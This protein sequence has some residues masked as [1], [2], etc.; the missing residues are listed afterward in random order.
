MSYSKEVISKQVDKIKETFKSWLGE[1]KEDY[2]DNNAVGLGCF[3]Y[4]PYD[5]AWAVTKQC[6]LKCAHCSISAGSAG[7]D[8]LSTEEGL[9][10]I[11][12]VANLGPVKFVFTGGE[13]L[14]R[15]DIF[16]LIEYA[17]SLNMQVEVATNGTLIDDNVAKRLKNAGVYEVAISMDGIGKI[18]D[19]IR[20]IKGTFDKAVRAIKAC[21]KAG[22]KVHF[23]TT[24]FK[25]NISE[26]SR[27]VDFAEQLQVDRI[28]IGTLVPVGRGQKI[29]HVC[30]SGEE[31]KQIFNFIVERQPKTRVWL[32]PVCPQFWAFLEAENL[33]DGDNGHKFIGCTAGITS[34]HILPNGD[35]DLCAELPLKVGNI[36]QQPFTTIIKNDIF[37]KFRNR[38][39]KGTCGNCKYLDICGGCRARAF[40]AYGSPLAEDPVC[41]LAK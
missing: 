6:N 4:K 11:E 9:S 26:L 31:V 33:L 40:A 22:L 29:S 1:H 30:L 32:R 2:F 37:K 7:K 3:N 13:A 23:H 27:I 38:E 16:E 8:E 15:K 24:I 18:H 17:T 28:Y 14:L 34:F 21:K 12:D 19:N 39:I 20:G 41:F 25:I 10:F 36:K 35:V 5:V